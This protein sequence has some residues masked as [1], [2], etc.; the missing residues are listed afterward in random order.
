MLTRPVLPQPSADTILRRAYAAC[1]D[2]AYRFD[3]FVGLVNDLVTLYRTP[4]KSTWRDLA[5]LQTARAHDL[6]HLKALVA[7][8]GWKPEPLEE[9]VADSHFR[10]HVSTEGQIAAIDRVRAL[11][12]AKC[13]EYI[14][15]GKLSC[16]EKEASPP[17]GP[18]SP[19]A[20][21]LN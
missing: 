8:L 13:Q 5:A 14:D 10:Q 9:S 19:P 21:A 16:P 17:A 18:S 2:S 20:P 4:T 15:T 12:Y 7:W 6:K 1:E 3:T 11:V